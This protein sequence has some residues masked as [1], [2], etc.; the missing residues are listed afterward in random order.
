MD[1]RTDS[2]ISDFKQLDST[3]VVLGQSWFAKAQIIE[4]LRVSLESEQKLSLFWLPGSGRHWFS[5]FP[6]LS[7][8]K[9]LS[10]YA[11]NISF[12]ESKLFDTPFE[13]RAIEVYN[14][15]IGMATTRGVEPFEVDDL[16]IPAERSL[17]Q[18]ARSSDMNSQDVD[19]QR[20][21]S[22]MLHGLENRAEKIFSIILEDQNAKKPRFKLMKEIGIRL[23][24]LEGQTCES[25][26]NESISSVSVN[27][28]NVQ[29]TNDAEIGDTPSCD[30]FFSLT[31]SSGEVIQTSAL[32]YA[33]SFSQ[34]K[35][36]EALSSEKKWMSKVRPDFGILQVALRPVKGPAPAVK[37]T[38]SF[39]AISTPAQ[40]I[41]EIIDP[42]SCAEAFVLPLQRESQDEMLR[43]A[44]G[45][46]VGPI[47]NS[48]D[49]NVAIG[50][51]TR[52]SQ[53]AES[54]QDSIWTTLIF[55]KECEDNHD[56]T[57]RLRRVKQAIQKAFQVDHVEELW[58]KFEL[59]SLENSEKFLKVFENKNNR[60]IGTDECG[61]LTLLEQQSKTSPS[62]FV[63][64]EGRAQGLVVEMQEHTQKAEFQA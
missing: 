8:Q 13:D 54:V 62:D 19:A 32:V 42:K 14:I 46:F 38:P 57:K 53:S 22:R 50:Q 44:F 33:D 21:G 39:A 40:E 1:K 28:T 9:T 64:V 18:A 25:I 24:R 30:G 47:S 49:A 61:L 5:V 58:L 15:R 17:I 10:R 52:Q 56:I 11:D 35:S 20:L 55:E 3:K 16:M 59:N 34:A 7:D 4:A 48:S 27:A 41:Q 45:Y 36:Y 29:S 6:Y 43:H 37:K 60:V 23:I 63:H 2:V 51:V 31:L 26:Q 12:I